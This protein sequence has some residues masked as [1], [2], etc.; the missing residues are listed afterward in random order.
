MRVESIVNPAAALDP[1]GVSEL[2]RTASDPGKPISLRRR[3]VAVSGQARLSGAAGALKALAQPGAP[4]E[5]EALT[6][7]GELGE[8]PSAVFA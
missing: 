7:L 3:I 2:M 1:A 5:A 8:L 4:L 6:A